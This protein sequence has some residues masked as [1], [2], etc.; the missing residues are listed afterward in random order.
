MPIDYA[1]R[2]TG[3]KRTPI[4]NRHL[5]FALAFV[6]GA[7]NAGGFLAVH[8]YTSHMTGIVSSMA[9]N[10]VLGT[11]DIVLGGAGGLVSFV[12]GAAT[13]AVLVNYAR[14][15]RMH[16]E[17]ALPL[18]VEATLLICFGALGA[19]L[20]SMQGFFVPVTVMLLC[21]IM[22]LQN[23]VITKLSHAEIR[24]THLTGIVTDIGIEL[25]KLFYRNASGPP[26]HLRVLAN[27]DRLRV[28]TLLVVFFFLG[29]VMG[30]VGFKHV[31]YVST[32]PL[33]LLLLVL[34]IVPAFDDL[35]TLA[36]RW[37]R[38]SRRSGRK[39]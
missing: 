2:L 28:L 11:Y 25:G 12:A 4:A 31:G 20:S 32:V 6:A 23:A 30:A 15:R 26:S 39:A 3:R 34:A 27:R 16:S 29:G 14:R 37:S 7:I 8:Q 19:R 17:Y 10:L 13:S 38:R 36:R 5:G 22:G 9:D 33:A 24:T 35:A 21:F 1:R 18:L